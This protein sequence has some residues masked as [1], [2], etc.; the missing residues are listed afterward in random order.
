MS[1]CGSPWRLRTFLLGVWVLKKALSLG[2]YNRQ[3]RRTL[4]LVG[5]AMLPLLRCLHLASTACHWA[6]LGTRWDLRPSEVE[7]TPGTFQAYALATRHY[8][9]LQVCPHVVENCDSPQDLSDRRRLISCSAKN[10]SLP[11]PSDLAK[12]RREHGYAW[13]LPSRVVSG[14]PPSCWRFSAS[15]WRLDSSWFVV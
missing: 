14:N 9:M 13:I 7:T 11:G 1:S 10:S 3:P 4:R 2:G 15:T 5:P 8:R 6:K 12:L